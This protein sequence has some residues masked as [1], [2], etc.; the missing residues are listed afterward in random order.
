MGTA[1]RAISIGKAPPMTRTI[2]L[3][4][5]PESRKMFLRDVRAGLVVK[6]AQ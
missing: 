1:L 3:H 5:V 2:E 4:E 6:V